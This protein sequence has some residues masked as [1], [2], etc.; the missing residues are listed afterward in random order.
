MLNGSHFEY[1]LYFFVGGGD[2]GVEPEPDII[3]LSVRDNYRSITKK[4][5]LMSVSWLG[6]LE[7]QERSQIRARE[8]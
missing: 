5:M 8:P 3:E 4:A 1:P 2:G 6:A 7:A